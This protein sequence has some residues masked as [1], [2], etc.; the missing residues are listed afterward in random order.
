M[1]EKL[2]VRIG[3]AGDYSRVFYGLSGLV[4]F[5]FKE[6]VIGPLWF[7]NNYG[8]SCEQYHGNNYISL[9][10]GENVES[11]T[12]G[13]TMEELDTVNQL[14]LETQRAKP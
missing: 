7:Y 2:Y 12:R 6:G 5:L 10:Y 14:L 11:P 3:D 1:S 13:L 8:V 9:Y 4:D